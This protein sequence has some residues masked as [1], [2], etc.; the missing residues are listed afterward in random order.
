MWQQT[1][2]IRECKQSTEVRGD[3]LTPTA[4]IDSS[5]RPKDCQVLATVRGASSG[6]REN[7]RSQFT[8]AETGRYCGPWEWFTTKK[9]GTTE[10]RRSHWHWLYC[11]QLP[12]KPQTKKCFNFCKAW[13]AHWR[14]STCLLFSNELGGRF[15]EPRLHCFY[16][17][18]ARHRRPWRN[19]AISLT[20]LFTVTENREGDT[21]KREEHR[22]FRR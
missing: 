11:L 20:W 15:E 1:R 4:N 16:C 5:T 17:N 18:K 2:S 8:F 22:S 6:S 3:I 13:E 12:P 10:T 21:E 19:Y 14:L 9:K 7:T